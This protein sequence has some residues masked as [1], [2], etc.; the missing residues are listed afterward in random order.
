MTIRIAHRGASG[1]APENTLL[2]FQKAIDMG[3]EGIELDV[4]ATSD[5]KAVIMHDELLDRTTQAKGLVRNYTLAQLQQIKNKKANEHILSLSETLS[6]LNGGCFL[7]IEI[8]DPEVVPDLLRTLKEASGWKPDQIWLSAFNWQL[9]LDIKKQA[10]ELKLGVL[11]ADHLPHAIQF[12]QQHELF[13]V[14]PYY[15]LLNK[16]L[17]IQIKSLGLR[18]FAWT[19]NEQTAIQKMLQLGVDGIITDYPD[20]I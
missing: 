20:K 11:T 16:K 3:C 18:T 17:C 12:A 6:Y 1:Y 19:V 13:A 2:A 15:G 7:N 9:L 14:H 5:G 10:P 8:K 4:R